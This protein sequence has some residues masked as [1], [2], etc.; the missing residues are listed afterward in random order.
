M[1]R[2]RGQG[3][4]VAGTSSRRRAATKD[5][6]R[7]LKA[8][9]AAG[10]HVEPCRARDG[11]WKVYLDGHYIGGLACTPTDHRSTQND[12]ARL[13]RNGLNIDTKGRYQP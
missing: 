11:H 2:P 5:T 6:R 8:I 13:R 4:A 12:I 9:E 7:L 3:G 1:S 10:G